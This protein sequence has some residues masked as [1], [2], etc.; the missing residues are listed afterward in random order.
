MEDE[1]SKAGSR[2]SHHFLREALNLYHPPMTQGDQSKCQQSSQE[3]L[4]CILDHMEKA[5]WH[6]PPSTPHQ[7]HIAK[8]SQATLL[9]VLSTYVKILLLSS[10]M[11]VLSAHLVV[12]GVLAARRVLAVLEGPAPV[13]L[14]GPASLG[15]LGDQGH[16]QRDR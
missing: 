5:H 12:P 7:P 14:E 4:P 16:L 8:R 11:G 13:H 10:I 9:P 3:A 6:V 15:D 1:D 2:T